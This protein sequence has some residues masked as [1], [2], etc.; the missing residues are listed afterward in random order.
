[1]PLRQTAESLLH[2]HFADLQIAVGEVGAVVVV[3]AAAAV[4]AAA[5]AKGKSMPWDLVRRA[6]GPEHQNGYWHQLEGHATSNCP[7][8]GCCSRT[9]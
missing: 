4:V 2:G 3:A 1:M 6:G 7:V 5:V 9:S 8:V